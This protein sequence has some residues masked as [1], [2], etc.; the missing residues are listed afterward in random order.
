MQTINSFNL[1]RGSKTKWFLFK[2]KKKVIRS[3]NSF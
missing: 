1:L 3:C 2:S